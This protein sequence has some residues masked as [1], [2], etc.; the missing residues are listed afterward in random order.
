MFPKNQVD[1]EYPN[2]PKHSG[3]RKDGR[4]LVGEWIEKM[5]DN[6]SFA[7][8]LPPTLTSPYTRRCG[9]AWQ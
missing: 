7:H 2:I 3:T 5:K 6:V 4:S 8:F 1:V 9:R